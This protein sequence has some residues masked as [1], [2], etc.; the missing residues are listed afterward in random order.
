MLGLGEL[1]PSL[2]LST[3]HSKSRSG[4]IT[5]WSTIR[6]T[7]PQSDLSHFLLPLLCSFL[8]GRICYTYMQVITIIARYTYPN[9][10]FIS[11]VYLV[12][13]FLTGFC[14]SAFLSVAG[15]TVSDLFDDVN[16]AWPLAVYTVSPFIGPAIG[17]LISGCVECIVSFGRNYRR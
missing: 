17:P 2:R 6:S 1:L 8:P 7:R 16:V 3:T 11:A 13:R 14:S 9:H 4:S 12:F 5:D 15:G 10:A